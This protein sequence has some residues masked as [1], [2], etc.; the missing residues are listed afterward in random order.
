MASGLSHIGVEC[1]KLV[2]NNPAQ[3]LT[4]LFKMTAGRD[5]DVNTR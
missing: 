2:S 1:A 4:V 3:K 5:G